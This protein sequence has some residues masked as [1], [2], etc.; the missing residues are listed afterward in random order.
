MAKVTKSAGAEVVKETKSKSGSEDIL[1]EMLKAGV[2]FGHHTSRWHPTA[3]S[4]IFT[5]R[6]GIHIINLEKT[7]E[8]LEE[9]KK[10]LEE[11]AKEGKL[12]LLV[13][14]KKQIR[15]TSEKIAKETGLFYMTERW[16]GG[17]LTNF[18]TIK[19]RLKRMKTLEEQF[20]TGEINKYVKKERF[21][22]RNELEK[23][24]KDLGGIKEMLKMPDVLVVVDAK[25]EQI[26]IREATALG[27]PVVALVDTNNDTTGL[28]HA[29]P[30][31]DDAPKSVELLLTELLSGVKKYSTNKVLTEEEPF[32]S[33]QGK[34]SNEKID[35]GLEALEEA[36]E[37]KTDQEELEEKKIKKSKNAEM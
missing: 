27:I 11:F 17:L 26:A 4:F 31:N 25:A 16:M 34:E 15:E 28:A 30:G 37:E 7:A 20:K 14:T 29:V 22:L 1:R 18:T 10:Y 3:A 24:N 33:A 13:A 32:D 9:A 6:G 12:V 19:T 36:I 2:H 21:V 23:L 5:E 8:A 35:E